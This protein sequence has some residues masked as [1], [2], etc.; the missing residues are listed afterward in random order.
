MVEMWLGEHA[1]D[2]KTVL[3]KEAGV[4]E[5]G[6]PGSVTKGIVEE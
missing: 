6:W 3:E 5:A 4:E 2:G 1:E